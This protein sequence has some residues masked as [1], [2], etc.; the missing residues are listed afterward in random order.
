MPRNSCIRHRV[1]LVDGSK[2]LLATGY[3]L[4]QVRRTYIY[5]SPYSDSIPT[6]PIKYLQMKKQR[7][8]DPTRNSV[9][10]S[11][12]Y[13]AAK[14][15]ASLKWEHVGC[16]TPCGIVGE[17]RYPGDSPD[18]AYWR[19]NLGIWRQEDEDARG[20]EFESRMELLSDKGQLLTRSLTVVSIF[21]AGL[22][23]SVSPRGNRRA[24]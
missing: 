6:C 24:L 23:T 1:T 7:K 9:C 4:A 5:T 13:Y 15:R 14:D 19:G 17:W 18:K 22:G 11:K 3:V 2:Q 20:V 21:F 8:K 12:H 16:F 10:F